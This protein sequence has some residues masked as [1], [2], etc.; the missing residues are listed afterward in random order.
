MNQAHG[1]GIGWV[2][3]LRDAGWRRSSCGRAIVLFACYQVVNSRVEDRKRIGGASGGSFS[4]AML[5]GIGAL[6]DV[7]V[8]LWL[9]NYNNGEPMVK[10]SGSRPCDT[11]Q[12]LLALTDMP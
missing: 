10:A 8:V 4:H 1:Q 5:G 12:N 3:Q 7:P 9:L 2:V 11:G 6:D